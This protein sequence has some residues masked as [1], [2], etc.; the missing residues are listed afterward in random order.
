[1]DLSKSGKLPKAPLEEVIFELHWDLDVLEN[2]SRKDTGFDLAQGIFAQ[3]IENEFPFHNRINDERGTIYFTPFL[4]QQFWKAEAEW[5]V[6]QLGPGMLAINDVE[7]S[8]HWE[9][10]FAP[11]ISS[12]IEK[13]VKAYKGD[14]S[15]NR[16]SLRYLDAF[17]IGDVDPINFVNSNFKLTISRNFNVPGV[18][19]ALGFVTQFVLDDDS[20]VTFNLSNGIKQ[21]GLKAIVWQTAI[22]KVGQLSLS[23]IDGWLTN[24]HTIVSNMFKETVT[25]EFYE[26]FK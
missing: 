25:A 15:F 18:L 24:S 1:M 22:E 2:G 23:E 26:K 11:L 5:P 20:K 12:S 7:K 8:Y 21:N 13:L 3:S 10:S 4:T 16:I 17:A 19:E 9:N 14:I 6:V